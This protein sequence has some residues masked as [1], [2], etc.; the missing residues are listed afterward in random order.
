MFN[1][2]FNNTFSTLVGYIASPLTMLINDKKKELIS[3]Y[4]G[5]LS[6]NYGF[7]RAVDENGGLLG[8]YA[9]NSGNTSPTFRDKLSVPS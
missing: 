7:S 1:R 2:L 5:V 6:V 8:C 9:E 3:S 4:R